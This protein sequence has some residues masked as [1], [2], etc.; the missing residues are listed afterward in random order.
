[1]SRFAVLVASALAF[2]ACEPPA[3]DAA[4]T[5]RKFAAAAMAGDAD[6]SWSLLSEPTRAVLT[7]AARTRAAAEGKPSPADGRR[8]ALGEGSQLSRKVLRAQVTSET[9]TTADV[10]VVDE[11]EA[12]E[13]VALVRET[14]GWRVDLTGALAKALK[15]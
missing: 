8:L 10:E 5:Y 15:H 4:T 14:G 7:D 3:P 9:A 1:V 2:V 11:K 13:H 12:H 6:T